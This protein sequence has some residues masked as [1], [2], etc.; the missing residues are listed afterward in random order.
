MKTEAQIRADISECGFTIAELKNERGWWVKDDQFKL[1]NRIDALQ[2]VL[3][4]EGKP[5]VKPISDAE[6]LR[7][8]NEPNER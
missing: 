2:W 1:L 6:I 4:N 8:A 5:T 7:Q 3:N